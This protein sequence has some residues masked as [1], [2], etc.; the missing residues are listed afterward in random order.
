MAIKRKIN[1][2]L[3]IILIVGIVLSAFAIIF[4][5]TFLKVTVNGDS[6]NPTIANGA[7]G[8]MVKVYDN[9]KIERFDVIACEDDF[10]NLYLIKR[11]VGLPNETIDLID[12][13]L[14]VNGVETYQECNLVFRDENFKNTNFKL[15]DNQ[16]LIV[17]DN[18]SNTIDPIIVDRSKIVAKNGFCVA[19]YD[20]TSEKCNYSRDY[21]SCPI[22]NRKWYWF[23]YGK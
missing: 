9:S 18:R 15:L 5:S 19:E 16:Y 7:K 6:M 2:I 21:S 11:V 14:Y 10:G 12:N 17:G 23:K 13:K 22:D 1:I 8:Y 4:R 3:N 20:I